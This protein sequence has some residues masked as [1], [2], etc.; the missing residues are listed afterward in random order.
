MKTNSMESGS[1]WETNI[2]LPATETPSILWKKKSHNLVDKSPQLVSVIDQKN[3]VHIPHY[4]SIRFHD[5][6]NILRIFQAKTFPL[7]TFFQL[8]IQHPS[9]VQVLSSEP[10]SH[11]SSFY[12]LLSASQT[13]FHAHARLFIMW[14]IR[15]AYIKLVKETDWEIEA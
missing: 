4:I 5:S 2:Y 15:E 11:A 14:C 10:R 13:V 8:L 9:C 12:V 3:P 7:C 1:S 6:T